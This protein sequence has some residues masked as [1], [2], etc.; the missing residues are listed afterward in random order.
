MFFAN[1]NVNWM[2]VK[3]L[4]QQWDSPLKINISLNG[5]EW[6]VWNKGL[7]PNTSWLRMK[8]EWDKD[9]FS[10]V[11]VL[12]LSTVT[13]S[14][15][16]TRAMCRQHRGSMRQLLLFALISFSVN[17]NS[18]LCQKTPSAVILLHSFHSIKTI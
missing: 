11:N 3:V 4:L 15:V 1:G 10:K 9:T 13:I 18:I 5:C 2:A 6:K 8:S 12:S 17:H 14:A 16:M 7:S